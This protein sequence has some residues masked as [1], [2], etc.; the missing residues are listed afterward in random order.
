MTIDRAC[1]VRALS[2]VAVAVFLLSCT[3]GNPAHARSHGANGC[4]LLA[5]VIHYSIAETLRSPY[6]D[7]ATDQGNGF[8]SN[9]PSRCTAA[10]ATT[11]RAFSEALRYTGIKLTWNSSGRK[12]FSHYCVSRF[13]DRCSPRPIPMPLNNPARDT[14]FVNTAW[15]IVAAGVTQRMPPGAQSNTTVFEPS[16]L[17]DALVSDLYVTFRLSRRITRGKKAPLVSDE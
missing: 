2:L 16:D 12:S 6:A 3:G 13:L 15:D 1:P 14:A 8:S 5:I 4:E 7:L 11:S 17:A 10:A 9:Q